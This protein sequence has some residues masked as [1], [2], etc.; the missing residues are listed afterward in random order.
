MNSSALR[1]M[2]DPEDDED[3]EEEKKKSEDDEDED[4]DDEEEEEET[5]RVRGQLRGDELRSDERI[6][7]SNRPRPGGRR[8]APEH[9]SAGNVLAASGRK[10]PVQVLADPHRQR[11]YS[12]DVELGAPR[13]CLSRSLTNRSE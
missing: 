9:V 3:D 12:R 7:G 5:W 13:A 2:G 6:G 8:S 4:D 11:A 1:A 10:K